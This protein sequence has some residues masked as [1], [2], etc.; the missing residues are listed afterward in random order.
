MTTREFEKEFKRLY[1]PLGMYALRI[2][3]DTSAAEDIVQEAFISI[4]QSVGVEGAEAP[5]NFKAYMY[6]AVRNGCIS[7][8]RQQKHPEELQPD[9]PQPD[10]AEIDTSERDARIWQAVDALP[11][12]CREIFLMS[13][14]DGLSNDEIAEELGLSV[15]TVKNQ[16][17]KAMSRLRDALSTGHRPFF[18]PFL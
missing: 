17:V 10:E 8:L 3:G 2:V 18:L 15:S 1:L 12:R 13:K 16:M 14:R 5:A 7:H 9:L 11:E 6:R 4:W